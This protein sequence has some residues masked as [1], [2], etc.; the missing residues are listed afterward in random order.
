MILKGC[1]VKELKKEFFDL[2][3]LLNKSNELNIN[4]TLTRTKEEKIRR[5]ML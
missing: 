4:N 2:N 5:M 3:I 1:Y